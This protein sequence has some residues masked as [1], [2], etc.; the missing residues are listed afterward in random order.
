MFNYV[1]ILVG[2]SLLFSIYIYLKV[3]LFSTN[4]SIKRYIALSKEN[5][6]S[7]HKEVFLRIIL[8]ALNLFIVL[9]CL[10]VSLFSSDMSLNYN[11]GLLSLFVVSDITLFYILHMKFIKQRHDILVLLRI[12]ILDILISLM[13]L[14]ALVVHVQGVYI[15]DLILYQNEIFFGIPKWNLL[16]LLP[17]YYLWSACRIDTVRSLPIKNMAHEIDRFQMRTL[18]AVR[19]TS[20]LMLSIVLF[21]GG[22]SLFEIFDSFNLSHNTLKFVELVFIVMK[23]IFLTLMIRLYSRFVGPKKVVEVEKLYRKRA[24]IAIIV[25]LLIAAFKVATI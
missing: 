3:E 10:N 21:M 4:I 12:G 17:L 5:N 22:S 13:I 7:N 18:Y 20:W 11:T 1:L 19:T 25:F 24:L 14:A 2:V 16:V 15:V 23:F 8:I 9:Y 6:F